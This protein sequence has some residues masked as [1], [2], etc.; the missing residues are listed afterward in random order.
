MKTAKPGPRSLCHKNNQVPRTFTCTKSTPTLSLARANS[1]Q[2]ASSYL[3][4]LSVG[5]ALPTEMWQN[6]LYRTLLLLTCCSTTWLST[7]PGSF[8]LLGF[9]QRTKCGLAEYILSMSTIRECWRGQRK[10]NST[11][12]QSAA[13]ARRAIS[14]SRSCLPS[15]QQL[16]KLR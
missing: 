16:P 2:S 13:G 8:W 4:S 3:R 6:Y 5:C 9:I 7:T 14:C 11:A 1:D 12:R 10:I 15:P